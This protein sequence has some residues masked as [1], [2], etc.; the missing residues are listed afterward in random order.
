MTLETPGY[1]IK[2]GFKGDSRTVSKK[3]TESRTLLT[4]TTGTHNT[5]QA[6]AR[7]RK[8]TIHTR[9]VQYTAQCTAHTQHSTYSVLLSTLAD[10]VQFVPSSDCTNITI[11]ESEGN[12]QCLIIHCSCCC[13]LIGRNLTSSFQISQ[14]QC[15]S[16]RLC[17]KDEHASREPCMSEIK[18]SSTMIFPYSI[19]LSIIE[20]VKE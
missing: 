3:S 6:P 1:P 11:N 7:T 15:E 19:P 18:L 9:S 14:R 12:K 2:P 20:F 16:C 17:S 8:N 5:S 10:D 4:G 13:Y